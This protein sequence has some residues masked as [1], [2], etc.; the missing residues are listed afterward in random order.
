VPYRFESILERNELYRITLCSGA[1]S[2]APKPPHFNTDMQFLYSEGYE[3]VTTS[4]RASPIPQC[5]LQ[6]MHLQ[7]QSVLFVAALQ[8]LSHRAGNDVKYRD[9]PRNPTL[10]AGSFGA[11]LVMQRPWL[12]SL[13]TWNGRHAAIARML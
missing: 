2:E 4:I 12:S 13:R 9:G 10:Q 7:N 11:Y 6:N 1:G 5:N 3:S 8:A